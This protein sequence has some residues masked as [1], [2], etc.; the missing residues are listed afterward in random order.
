[1]AKKEKVQ[2]SMEASLWDSCNKLRSQMSATQ[3]MY[4]VLGL[5]FLKFAD[6]KFE[7][8]R[9]QL[10]AGP[11]KLF[12]EQP[13]FYV[14]EG[15]F[16]IPEKAR[17]TYIKDH[18][19]DEANIGKIIDD[20]FDLLEKD[21]DDLKGALK[22]DRY[23][24]STLPAAN[25][26]SL[27]N[28]LDK[29]HED[30]QH[31]MDDLIGKVYQ[32]FINKFAIGT[33]K[34]KGEFYT[35][36]NIV[37][38]IVDLIEPFHGKIY[39]PCCG[40][41]G[42]FVQSEKFVQRYDGDLSIYGQ[43]SIEETWKLAKMNLAIRGFS[44]SLGSKN[45]D[46]FF[47][48]QFKDEKFDYII[49]NPPFNTKDWRTK[50]QLAKDPRWS[51]YD[52]VPPVSNANYAWILHMLSKLSYNGIA[53]FLLAN[54]ALGSSGEEQIIRSRIIKNHKVEAIIV[55][56]MNM[57]Y[58]TNISVTLW[59][60]ENRKSAR[61]VCLDGETVHLRD[62]T[63]DVLMM[64]LRTMGHPNSDGFTELSEEEVNLV[65][66]VFFN[67]RSPERKEKY[68]DKIEF[69]KSVSEEELAQHDYSLIPSD[70]LGFKDEDLE[71]DFST[72]MPKLQKK[73]KDLSAA[74]ESTN[75]K[76]K[77]ALKG[78]GYGID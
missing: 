46:T 67:W 8:R 58:Y 75:N 14:Q 52:A 73:I 72:E 49:A 4:F 61:D 7:K 59:I 76:T 78:I 19:K 17:W 28:D 16:Y 41:G 50:E 13:S 5:V 71:V 35:P 39:D 34:E 36:D 31:P 48:D 74:Q 62:R 56:P 70:Y 66:S 9:Q 45:A 3:Y 15:V 22:T 51:G 6:L 12:V 54:G 38:L 21:N 44:A 53:G 10:L 55:L 47:D 27:I 24:K 20:A 1:M 2:K 68:Q 57:F 60:L 25:L 32:Y 42:M 37:D 23:E 40:T 29:I 63:N 77:D 65:K 64:N 33:K 11:D 26:A 30:E 43:E 18:A 69:W